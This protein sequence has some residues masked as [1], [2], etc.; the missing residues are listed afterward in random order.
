MQALLLPILPAGFHKSTDRI[1]LDGYQMYAVDHWL[2]ARHCPAPVLIVHTGEPDHKII[3]NAYQPDS[4]ANWEAT[5]AL[6]RQHAKPK[7]TPHGLVMVTSLAQFR[8]D[9][10]IV[11]IPA[12]DLDAARSQLYTNINLHTLGCGGRSGLTLED[13]SDATKERFTSTYHLPWPKSGSLFNA[14]VLELIRLVQLSLSF[15]GYYTGEFDGLLCDITAEGIRNWTAQFGG[16]IDDS[17]RLHPLDKVAGPSA[18]SALLSLVIAVRNRLVVIASSPV[19]ITKDPFL[20]PQI[21]LRNIAH[22]SSSGP[23]PISQTTSNQSGHA[24]SPRLSL[25]SPALPSFLRDHHAETASSLPTIHSSPV[26]IPPTFR[27]PSP[28]TSPSRSSAASLS[29]NVPTPPSMTSASSPTHISLAEPEISLHLTRRLV[30]NIFTVYVSRT[31]GEARRAVRRREKGKDKDDDKARESRDSLSLTIPNRVPALTNLPLHLALSGSSL[32]SPQG[33]AGILVPITDLKEFVSMLIGEDVE[34]KKED[35]SDGSDDGFSKA[36]A[37][38]KAKVRPKKHKSPVHGVAGS[39][40]AVW[41]GCVDEAIKARKKFEEMARERQRSREERGVLSDGGSLPKRKTFGS[42]GSDSDE[43][44]RP[45]FSRRASI[46]SANDRSDG[47]STEEEGGLDAIGSLWA[48]SSGKV[49]RTIESLTGFNTGRRKTHPHNSSMSNIHSNMSNGNVVDLGTL[50]KKRLTTSSL[51]LPAF[52]HGGTSTS[53]ASTPMKRWPYTGEG[54][55]EDLLS[56]GQVSPVGQAPISSPFASPRISLNTSSNTT[57]GEVMSRKERKLMEKQ[58]NEEPGQVKKVEFTQLRIP[59]GRQLPSSGKRI[60]FTSRVSSW[61]DPISAMQ[62]GQDGDGEEDWEKVWAESD[63]DRLNNEDDPLQKE[64]NIDTAFQMK[65]RD[66]REQNRMSQDSASQYLHR[67]GQ[68]VAHE[69]EDDPFGARAR[70]HEQGTR[71]KNPELGVKRRR[72]FH[73]SKFYKDL[74]VLPIERMRIDVELC[75]HFL[76]IHRREEHLKNVITMLKIIIPRLAATG[77][78]LSE[79]YEL[80]YS[81]LKQLQERAKLIGSIDT[82]NANSNKISQATNTLRYEAEQFRVP[83]LWHLA[84]PP[85]QKVLDMRQQVFGA[86]GRKLAPGVHG[87][88]GQFNRLQWTLDGQERLVDH[89]GR[90]EEEAEEEKAVDPEGRFIPQLVEDEED[91]VQHPSIKPMWLLHFFTNWARWGSAALTTSKDKSKPPSEEPSV[92]QDKP[93]VS[94]GK[95]EDATKQKASQKE[96]V[97]SQ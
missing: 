34:V 73:S 85:R 86:G 87:A 36:T 12:G 67:R 88:H 39:V 95:T 37:K 18:V 1:V 29:M 3:V 20:Y 45:S 22:Y 51:L 93:E 8:S 43:P 30:E 65:E 61:A 44:W 54:D 9:Y 17:E 64:R 68:S 5:I 41:L 48:K 81:E 27:F 63:E 50:S 7:S 57:T 38:V 23:Q 75:G 6:F 69:P 97:A 91:V 77:A 49:T 35:E 33:A 55:D 46:K 4:D 72:S 83:E 53:G 15:F 78:A 79:Q 19:P 42:I 71:K 32:S 84:S 26:S 74:Q 2:R 59:K 11:H 66:R 82:H 80:H 94:H 62:E 89:L 24:H 40:K 21:F 76:M 56:S 16:L 92:S 14:C 25:Q 52:D 31:S 70:R 96:A 47:R 58:R 10:T 60:P 28:A 90:T 13:P